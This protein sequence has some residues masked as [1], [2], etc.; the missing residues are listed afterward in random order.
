MSEPQ[1]SS[2]PLQNL[3]DNLGRNK[4]SGKDQPLVVM[5]DNM[6]A[7]FQEILSRLPAIGAG[8]PLITTVANL[9]KSASPG[10]R[11]F[12]TDALKNVYG[13]VVASGG[14]VF[15]PVYFDATQSAWIVG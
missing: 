13:L 10:T 11:A 15:A 5:V 3:I 12:V 6:I 2:D 4:T 1:Y 7:A 9:P 14:A 8:T